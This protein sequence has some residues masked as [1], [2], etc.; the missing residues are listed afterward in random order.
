MA[1]SVCP[2]SHRC[3]GG[4][5][6]IPQGRWLSLSDSEA[7]RV[8]HYTER[9]KAHAPL[10]PRTNVATCRYRSKCSHLA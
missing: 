2:V 3:V 10:D 1:G 5:V 6:R 8:F 9:K 4:S 7:V